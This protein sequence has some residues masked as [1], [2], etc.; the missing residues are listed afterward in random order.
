VQESCSTRIGSQSQSQSITLQYAEEPFM[1][2]YAGVIVVI[3]GAL[4][5][6]V[7]M[8]FILGSGADKPL[9]RA[10]EQSQTRTADPNASNAAGAPSQRG[11]SPPPR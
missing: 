3:A 11:E 9:D 4:A 8:F 6:V 7:L 10:T 5:G 2:N 1:K